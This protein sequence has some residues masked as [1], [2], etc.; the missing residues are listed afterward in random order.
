M[1]EIA[2]PGTA[3]YDRLS[4]FQAYARAGV[5]EYWIVNPERRS[6]EVAF[7]LGGEYVPQGVFLGKD[8]LPSRIVPGIASISVDLSSL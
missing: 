8:T 6:I 5:E 4:K 3:A 2:S 7:L 1:I